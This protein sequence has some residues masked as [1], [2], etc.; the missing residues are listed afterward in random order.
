MKNKLIRLKSL[1]LAGSIFLTSS[2]LVG[3]SSSNNKDN[4][5]SIIQTETTIY[6]I[7]EHILSVPIEED[8]RTC[9][10]QYEYH[11]GYEPV[12]ISLKAYGQIFNNYGGGAILYSNTEPVEC[13]SIQTSSSDE[14][15]SLDFGTPLSIKQTDEDKKEKIKEFGV[16]EHIISI[17]L[18]SDN[19]T[20]NIQYEYHEG[21]EVV[22]I[23]TTSY[24]QR[25]NNFGGGVILYKNITPVKCNLADNGYTM[26]GIPFETEKTKIYK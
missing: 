23:A 26:F 20:D 3:C 10:F 17:P 5:T 18:T 6:D 13:C 14:F 24:G 12:G 16:G 15:L 1:I 4:E 11:P 8:I 2:S 22:G 25:F 9:N 7:G 21:Y 19:S